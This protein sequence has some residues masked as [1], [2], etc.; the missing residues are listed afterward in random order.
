LQGVLKGLASAGLP[1]QGIALG[2]G[3]ERGR[4]GAEFAQLAAAAGFPGLQPMEEA[5]EACA[6]LQAAVPSGGRIVACGS[7]VLVTP[8]LEWLLAQG[9]TREP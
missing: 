7:F 4:S 6:V 9:A 8:V 2:L 1:L 5:P 3:G